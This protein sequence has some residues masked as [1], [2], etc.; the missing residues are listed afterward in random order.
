M[1]RGRP[2]AL[3][4]VYVHLV[5]ATW[6]RLPLLTEEVT[7]EVRQLLA[8]E[9]ARCGATIVAFGGVADHLHV[10]VRLPATVAIADLV[11]RLKGV[12]A[13]HLNRASST[14]KPFKWQS[15]YGAFSVGQRQLAQVTDY[16]AR[17]HEHH[18]QNAPVVHWEAAVLDQ[19]QPAQ[20]AGE[21]EA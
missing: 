7:P 12:S 3:V 13:R 10:L 20:E 11:K 14:G 2:N 15:A 1:S 18:A 8:A 16:I 5:W 19:Q 9:A 21:D 4:A 6:A 17:Q